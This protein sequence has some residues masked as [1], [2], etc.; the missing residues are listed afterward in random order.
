MEVL[1]KPRRWQPPNSIR[2][3]WKKPIITIPPG[4]FIRL[5]IFPSMCHKVNRVCKTAIWSF[6]SMLSNSVSACVQF[7]LEG[8]TSIRYHIF[9]TK[10]DVVYKHHFHS[11]HHQRRTL[12]KQTNTCPPLIRCYVLKSI[13]KNEC[14]ARVK[15][16]QHLSPTCT[17]FLI[18][19]TPMNNTHFTELAQV[20]QQNQCMK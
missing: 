18:I 9:R 12:Y 2:I 3:E 16:P 1:Q 20:W 13:S 4:I 6:K 7:S 11:S 10:A 19:L 15:N 8:T 14:P 5:S 17:K